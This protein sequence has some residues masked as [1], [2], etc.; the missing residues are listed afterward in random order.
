MS[1]LA[2]CCA[3]AACGQKSEQTLLI[4]HSPK[5][6]MHA[7]QSWK[8]LQLEPGRCAAAT[9]ARNHQQSLVSRQERATIASTFHKTAFTSPLRLQTLKHVLIPRCVFL[10]FSVHDFAFRSN[11]LRHEAPPRFV[12]CS[13]HEAP[14]QGKLDR[15]KPLGSPAC[16][17]RCTVSLFMSTTALSQTVNLDL[18]RFVLAGRE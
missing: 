12:W 3:N 14:L 8:S 7:V 5:S 4:F 1:E 11:K 17:T 10:Q 6:E 18:C 15:I 16:T 2:H 13:Q 9:L